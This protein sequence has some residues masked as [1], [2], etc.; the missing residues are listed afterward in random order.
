MRVSATIHFELDEGLIKILNKQ[1]KPNVE[2]E[3]T[4]WI[5]STFEAKDSCSVAGSTSVNIISI[6]GKA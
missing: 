1:W 3:I 2:R 4:N 5:M 6:S